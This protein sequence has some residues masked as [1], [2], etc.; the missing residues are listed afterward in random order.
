D[1]RPGSG[2]FLPVHRRFAELARRTPGALAVAD[3]GRRVS[4]GE[5]AGWSGALARRL[6]SLGVGPEARVAV[7]LPRSPEL[8]A[9]VLGV[10]EAGG[11]YVALDPGSPRERLAFQLQD[12]G[13]TVL[14][15]G[16]GAVAGLGE[17]LGLRCVF[18]AEETGRTVERGPEVA[19]GNLAYVI[20]T[21]GS[22]GQ[23]KGVEISHGSLLALVDWHVRAFGVA[24][25]DRGTLLAG[26]GFDASVWEMWP[27]LTT[28]AAL[29]VVPDEVRATPAALI[30][31]L[32]REG[33]TVS[34]LPTPLAEAVLPLRWPRSTGLR[35]LLTGGD[36]LHLPPPPSVPFT[37][38][39]NYG[40]TEATVVATSGEV[41][42]GAID[43][44]P[45]I[46]RPLPHARA[47]I[48]DERLLPLPAGTAGT[49]GTPGEL[50]VGG[51]G[52]ARGYLGRPD[53]TAERFVPDPF[54]GPGERLY[55]TG[56][57][58]RTGAGGELEFLGRIDD[59]VKIRGH[60]IELGEVEAA[61]ARHPGVREGVVTAWEDAEGGQRLVG[62]VVPEAPAPTA[63]ELRELMLESLPDSMVPSGFVFLESLPYTA[64]GKVDRR[65]LPEPAGALLAEPGAPPRTATE[66]RLAE[67]WSEVLRCG[68]VGVHDS[69]FELG[70]HSLLATRILS[71]VADL[72]GVELPLRALLDAPTVADLAARI[73]S[74]AVTDLV[75]LAPLSPEERAGLLPLSFAQEALWFL[76]RLQPGRPV[77]NVISRAALRGRLDL[78]ALAGAL[79]A[80][81]RRH[82]SLR[83]RFPEVDGEPRQQVEPA[84][85]Y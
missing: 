73:D 43:G 51:S 8:V 35:F 32:A 80:L 21:S 38:I 67:L 59:Q 78:A 18:P 27:C 3:G 34:F 75:P 81:L 26:V 28:G 13:A 23:P 61:L 36:R 45:P 64:S 15:A 16:R 47:F 9:S 30:E 12:C 58:V 60:R 14:L 79:D 17:S 22:T 56:D 49:A 66:A 52:L 76:D 10:L 44:L 20:Y 41:P 39:N 50:L 42:P 6:R 29:S 84:M 65:A 53:L 4:Y 7:C 57:L 74:A 83:T 19:P 72:F 11:A 62:Y 54:G 48:V 46:G 71:R 37:L 63:R 40:P 25:E 69:F 70:G 82:D 77:Y 33:V 85:P 1:A 68:A 31:W 55:R 2:R 24:A 5:L